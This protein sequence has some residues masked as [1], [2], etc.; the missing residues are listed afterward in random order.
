MSKPLDVSMPPDLDL[1]QGYSLRV[2][3]LDPNT[4]SLVT[5]VKVGQVVLT[6]VNVQAGPIEAGSFRLLAG[7]SA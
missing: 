1:D 5:G 6:V 2:T 7:P 3:A 4:G